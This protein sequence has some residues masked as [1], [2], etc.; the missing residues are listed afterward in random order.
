MQSHA[1]VAR[2]LRLL[3]I[4]IL[5]F[6]TLACTCNLSG[7]GGTAAT[8]TLMNSGPA[9]DPTSIYTPEE[10]ANEGQH[11]YHQVAEEFNCSTDNPV[12]DY[13]FLITFSPDSVEIIPVETPDG[14]HVYDQAAANTY[15][16]M[17][18]SGDRTYRVTITFN[19]QGFVLFSEYSDGGQGYVP[20]LR[21]T[22]TRID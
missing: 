18:N 17:S 7:T 12:G 16:F 19:M 2:N 8:P 5:V 14:G 21:Y 6:V 13:Q 10:L 22:R 9:A 11:T 15:L 1:L 20:C 4:L 3:V